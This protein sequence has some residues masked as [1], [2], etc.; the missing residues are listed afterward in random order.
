MRQSLLFAKRLQRVGHSRAQGRH[1]RCSYADAEQC[2]PCSSERDG[3]QRADIKAK[4]ASPAIGNGIG[5]NAPTTKRKDDRR[6]VTIA[7][8]TMPPTIP[9]DPRIAPWPR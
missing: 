2:C 9:A 4:K 8:A 7:A 5:T 1:E 6:R 3:I